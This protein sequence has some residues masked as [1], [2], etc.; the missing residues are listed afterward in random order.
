MMGNN[1]HFLRNNMEKVSLNYPFYPLSATLMAVPICL[2]VN[3]YASGGKQLCTPFS[4]G[5]NT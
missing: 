5:I 3:G 1:I 4:K 2:K